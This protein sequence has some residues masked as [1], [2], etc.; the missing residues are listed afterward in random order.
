M[1]HLATRKVTGLLTT[2]SKD[3]TH[4]LAL[5]RAIVPC[6]TEQRTHKLID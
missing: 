2:D 1:T 6:V 4:K 5:L 3:A